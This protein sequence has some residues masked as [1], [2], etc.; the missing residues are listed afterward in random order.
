RTRLIVVGKE[1]VLVLG[2]TSGVG[3]AIAQ[4]YAS[5]GAYVC[6]VG[7]REEK[8][9]DVVQECVELAAR[10]GFEDRMLRVKADVSNVNEMVKVRETLEKGACLM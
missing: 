6:V 7:R 2:A 10:N 3:C 5:R 4:Q 8:L 1:R 9:N